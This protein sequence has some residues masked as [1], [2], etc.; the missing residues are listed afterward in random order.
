MTI[1]E[2]V[3]KKAPRIGGTPV[4]NDEKMD[5]KSPLPNWGSFSGLIVGQPG[6]GKTSLLLSLLKKY[7]KKRFDRIYLFSGSANTLPDNFLDRL[8]PER[9]YNNL[10]NFEE[11][12]D[13]IKGSDDKTLIIIDDLVKEI[14]EKKKP[15]MSALWNRRHQGGG[16]SYFVVS[17]KLNAIPLCLRVAFDAIM[18]FNITNKKEINSLF[19]DYITQ[20]DRKEFDDIIKYIVNKKESHPFIFIDKKNGEIYNKFNKL[21]LK[22]DD[23]V[24]EDAPTK[25]EAI[26]ISG[27]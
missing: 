14:E 17:Q 3:N 11:V 26:E 5:V 10:D 24:E 8:N 21:I 23:K 2:I 20:Y 18:F 13:D 9:I 25:R 1:L 22:N 6:S 4:S 12:I 16:V 15:L 27:K 7:Y 19:D